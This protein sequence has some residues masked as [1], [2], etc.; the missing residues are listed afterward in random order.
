MDPA[1]RRKLFLSYAPDWVITIAL[2][3]FFFLIEKVGGY[4]RSFSLEDTSL[5]HTYAVHERIPNSAL[6]VICFVAP[7]VIL[8]IINLLS[9][10]SYWDLHTSYLGLVLS[11]ALTGS[12]TQ[13]VKITVGRPR[14]DVIARCIPPIGS[15]DPPFGL[16]TVDICTQTDMTILDDGWRSFPSGHSSFSF[17]G[18]GFLS[19]YIAGKVHLF[20]RRGH[21]PKAWLSVAPLCGAAL[22]AVSR[23]MD[24]RHHWQDVTVGSILGITIAF[25]AYRQYYPSLAATESHKPYSPRIRAENA[26]LPLHEPMFPPGQ[27]GDNSETVRLNGSPGGAQG[28]HD[29]YLHD[30]NSLEM[31]PPRLPALKH[32]EDTPTD[33][34]K[35]HDDQRT[36]EFGRSDR[37]SL[38]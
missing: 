18:L 11:L 4:K 38:Q 19:F 24:Y 7:V 3:V 6:I 20:D 26:I 17:A 23:T 10:R 9:V 15:V 5:R 2:A 37:D 1:R 27:S 25:F 31:D 22:V 8:P 13:I 28:Y 32:E 14:P 35:A 21:A 29:P 30:R 16:S 36:R 12:I 34:W 33:G